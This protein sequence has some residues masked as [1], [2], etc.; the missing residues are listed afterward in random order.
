MT[1]VK[2]LTAT[3]LGLAATGGTAFAHHGNGFAHYLTDHGLFAVIAL[4]ATAGILL[5]ARKA[6]VK[7]EK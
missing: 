6:E 4:A 2:T 7:G 5:Q 1:F 3:A